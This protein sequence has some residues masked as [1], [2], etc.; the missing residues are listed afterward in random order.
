MACKSNIMM[1][2]VMILMSLSTCLQVNKADQC[3]HLLLGSLA[4]VGLLE[5]TLLD[6]LVHLEEKVKVKGEERK[7][8]LEGKR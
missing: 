7:T 8:K 2:M 1:M 3:V 4:L 5:Q 6:H